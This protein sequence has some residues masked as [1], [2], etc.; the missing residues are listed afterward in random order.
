MIF[1]LNNFPKNLTE[2][3]RRR[4]PVGD[5][6]SSIFLNRRAKI[7]EHWMSDVNEC[8]LWIAIQINTFPFAIQIILRRINGICHFDDKA[9]NDFL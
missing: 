7:I 3:R 9:Y 6:T 8:I 4:R 1:F 2:R 5:N